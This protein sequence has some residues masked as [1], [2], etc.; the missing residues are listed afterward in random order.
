MFKNQRHWWIRTS[1]RQSWY[2]IHIRVLSMKKLFLYMRSLKYRMFPVEYAA[3]CCN[4]ITWL[5]HILCCGLYIPFRSHDIQVTDDNNHSS[6][7]SYKGQT[8]CDWYNMCAVTHYV[9]QAIKAG[10]CSVIQFASNGTQ[11]GSLF[12]QNVIAFFKFS[13]CLSSFR[14][15]SK[16]FNLNPDGTGN[17]SESWLLNTYAPF[18]SFEA[19]R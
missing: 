9:H 10:F 8:L 15:G 3:V 5:Y 12:I 16:Y 14:T 1:E 11:I 7:F 17:H 6:Y 13:D 4:P 18:I 19:V 2:L